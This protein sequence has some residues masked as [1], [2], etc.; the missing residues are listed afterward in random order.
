MIKAI[1]VLTNFVSRFFEVYK[2]I[3]SVFYPMQDFNLGIGNTTLAEI[4]CFLWA[5][6]VLLIRGG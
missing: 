3:V 2:N 6:R 1:A 4:C 5:R